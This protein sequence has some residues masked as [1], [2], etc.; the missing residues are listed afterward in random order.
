MKSLFTGIL[1]KNEE[2]LLK[3]F[4]THPLH[5]SKNTSLFSMIQKD[6]SIGYIVKGYIQIIKTDSNANR[7]LIDEFFDGETFTTN[8]FSS[9]SNDY[10]FYTK[11]DT[12]LILI[13]YDNVLQWE[14]FNKEYY[15]QFIKNLL[16]ITNE[17]MQEKNERIEI[18]IQ[19]N[20]RNKLLE[21][22]NLMSKKHSSKF[23]YLPYNF[24]DLA[25]YL[26]VDRCAMSRELKHLK[27]EGFI[28]IKGKRITLLYD[29]YSSSSHL[30]NL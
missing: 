28:E 3:M 22:F 8:L 17:K 20:I 12:D 1:P 7:T 21:Y 14:D 23:I 6:N 30:I 29:Q 10:D 11:E 2:K 5:I 24:T 27:E 19:K 16:E 18:L 15:T 25:D 4:E 26:A 13:S 9:N